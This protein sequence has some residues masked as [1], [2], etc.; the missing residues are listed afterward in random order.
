MREE[1]VSLHSKI[2]NAENR[3]RRSNLR[4][5]GLPVS[6][7]DVQVKALA[8]FQKLA[9]DIP[10]DRLEIERAHRA[11]TKKNDSGPPRDIIVKF[12]FFNSKERLMAAA[13]DH[14]QPLRFQ[15]NEYQLFT[16]LAPTLIQKSQPRFK[17]GEQ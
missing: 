13:R 9:S 16:D 14:Q 2:E 3:S 5:R 15:G 17:K 6:I 8:L 10:V 11:L 7:W 4:I 1:N 12:L